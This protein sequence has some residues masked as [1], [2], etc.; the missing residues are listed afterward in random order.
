LKYAK[1]AEKRAKIEKALK[2]LEDGL[3]KTKKK[4]E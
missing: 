4:S 1:D 2:K 3:S